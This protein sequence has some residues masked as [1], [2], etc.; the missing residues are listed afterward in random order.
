MI[1]H[2]STITNISNNMF[3]TNLSFVKY[4]FPMTEK[5]EKKYENTIKT[6][7]TLKIEQESKKSIL[8]KILLQPCVKLV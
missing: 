4:S 7:V 3:Q 1:V 6:E 8:F 5:K 2:L